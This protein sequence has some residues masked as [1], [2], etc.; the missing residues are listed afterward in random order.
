MGLT[1]ADGVVA[2]E[3]FYIIPGFYMALVLNEKYN[4]PG[5][6]K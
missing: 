2:V 6:I 5:A 4:F 3:A 1:M